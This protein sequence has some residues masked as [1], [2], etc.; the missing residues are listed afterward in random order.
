MAKLNKLDELI[1]EVLSEDTFAYKDSRDLPYTKN[2]SRKQ[3][4]FIDTLAD[5]EKPSDVFD[6]KDVEALLKDPSRITYAHEQACLGLIAGFNAGFA[7]DRYDTEAE[8]QEAARAIDILRQVLQARDEFIS[9]RK[10]PRTTLTAPEFASGR[11][12]GLAGSAT[13]PFPQDQLDIVRRAMSKYG[14]GAFKG[15]LQEISKMSRR[16]Y[17]ASLGNKQSIDS[18][19]NDSIS[20]VLNNIMLIDVFNYIVKDMDAGSGGYL[21]EYFMALL[22]EGKVT[23]KDTTASGKMGAT[24]FQT[25]GGKR[26][27]VKYYSDRNISQSPNSFQ[28]IP[29]NTKVNYIAGIKRQDQSQAGVK[30]KDGK[31]VAKDTTA[32]RADPARIVAVDLYLFQIYQHEEGQFKAGKSQESVAFLSS[33]DLSLGKFITPQHFV[34]TIQLCAS[35]TQ[36][37]QEMMDQAIDNAGANL[38][39][40][41][42]EM[43]AMFQ[44]ITLAKES[45]KSYIST[46]DI[47]VGNKAFESLIEAEQAYEALVQ[48]LSDEAGYGDYDSYTGT[49]KQKTESKMK[50]LDKLILEV[51]KN[52]S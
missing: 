18:I 2:R 50:D 20:S 44:K 49:I 39:A 4:G 8:E 25:E 35:P 30:R 9:K 46:G 3:Q 38:V 47:T 48:I 45:S 36:N 40:A 51:I 11:G 15:R 43:K 14:T 26:G 34:G 23:G 1:R 6:N 10:Q 37:F 33:G 16:F 17:N 5:I 21:F 52:N 29:L 28:G 42:E 7:N 13:A 19:K 12:E 41:V 31:L 24:D 32:G 22:F 27:S